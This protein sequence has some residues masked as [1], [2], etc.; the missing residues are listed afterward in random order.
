LIKIPEKILHQLD[1]VTVI[2]TDVDGTLVTDGCLFCNRE[3]FT[4]RN[5]QAIYRLLSAG[6]D[7]V[8]TS[9]RESEKLSDTA[10]LL[11]FQN[12][13][14][15]LGIE[16]VYNQGKKVITNFGIDVEDHQSLKN[17]IKNTRVIEA[18]LSKFPEKI[19]F[20]EPWA[21]ILRTH[22][23]MIGEVSNAELET[24]FSDKFPELRIIDNG[25]VAPYK[26]FQKPHTYHILPK[27]VGKKSAIQTD[28]KERKLETNNLIGI[29]DS[30]EDMSMAD[31]VALFF[32]LDDH[33]PVHQPNI[34]RV[35]NSQGEGFSEIVDFLAANS[36]L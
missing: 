6:V 33:L 24:L 3:G 29:G 15:N 30:L 32:L 5:T 20:Y 26:H 8:M 21:D 19:T 2:Y 10:R 23:L 13:I 7:V 14:A 9:G 16:I 36:R 11:G 22:Y 25:E 17:W 1:K 27:S 34:F 12:Y 31:E 4:M 28:K 18:L 35:S